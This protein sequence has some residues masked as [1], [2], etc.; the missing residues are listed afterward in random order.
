MKNEQVRFSFYRQ[1]LGECL[2]I[3]SVY[4]INVKCPLSSYLGI[5]I[6]ESYERKSKLAL[7]HGPILYSIFINKTDYVAL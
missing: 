5:S 6:I 3:N 7:K 1:H 2:G 4:H